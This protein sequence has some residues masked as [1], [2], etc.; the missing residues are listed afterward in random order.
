MRR[1][2]KR[3]KEKDKRYGENGG[4]WEFINLKI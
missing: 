3:Q 2:D 4:I 1:K